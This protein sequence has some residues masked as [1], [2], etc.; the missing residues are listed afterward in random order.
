MCLVPILALLLPVLFLLP[1]APVPASAESSRW[2][3]VHVVD[4]GPDSETVRINVPVK[5]VSSLLPLVKDGEFQ[6]GH[7]RL[8]GK[9]MDG[10]QLRAILAAL[11]EAENGEY[12]RVEGRDENVRIEKQSDQF[13]VHVVD[14]ENGKPETVRIQVRMEVVDALLSGPEDELNLAAAVEAM[15]PEHGDLITVDGPDERVRIW[16]DD[17]NTTD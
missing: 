16:V 8:D 3:H 2:L 5:L 1:V 14:H 9:D 15:Q 13:L 7:L 4:S 17:R 6:G 10:K 12:V 11:R